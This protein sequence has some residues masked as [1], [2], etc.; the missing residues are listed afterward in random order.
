MYHTCLSNVACK[1]YIIRFV[2]HFKVCNGIY[3][4]SLLEVVHSSQINLLMKVIDGIIIFLYKIPL[5]NIMPE[6]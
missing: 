4:D 5:L 2:L 1:A 6:Y 3:I